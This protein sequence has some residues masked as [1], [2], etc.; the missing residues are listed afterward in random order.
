MRIITKHISL[1][2]R[3][4]AN[5]LLTAVVIITATGCVT[6]NGECPVLPE[7]DKIGVSLTIAGN[8]P[9]GLSRA[10]EPGQDS[11][12]TNGEVG[13]LAESYININDLFIF[14]FALGEE[15]TIATNDSKLKDILWSPNKKE[16]TTPQSTI[17]SDG[18]NVTL[19]T[20][21]DSKK[22]NTTDKFCIV[23][24]ANASKWVDQT[25]LYTDLKP[26]ETTL[27]DL[28]K[29]LNYTNVLPKQSE[30][31]QVLNWIPNNET[32][33]G[34]PLFGIKRVN[35][36]GYNTEIYNSGNPYDLGTV[37]LLRA[38]AKIEISVDENANQDPIEGDP[39]DNIEIESAHI[40]AGNWNTGLQLIPSPLTR[41]EGYATTGGTGQVETGPVFNNH[42]Y[43]PAQS[44]NTLYFTKVT[45]A[46][47][48]ESFIAYVP[49][50]DLSNGK[51]KDIIQ[52]KL[53]G[54]DQ[55]FNLSVSPYS[56]GLPSTGTNPYWNCIL[57]N[58]I[59]RYS[60]KGVE[61]DGSLT[62]LTL[63]WTVCPMDQV[64]ITIPPFD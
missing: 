24:V 28:Q 39:V 26:G 56:D 62:L 57:R 8:L 27:G 33:S 46:D 61:I 59:Y 58:H 31:N 19:R 36:D 42:E 29:G 40:K 22:Y 3:H 5:T 37:W 54:I 30:S 51:G 60:I 7:E 50:Y 9:S 43:D 34:I 25:S 14:T 13:T 12:D 32:S 48:K 38:L 16:I 21:L 6:E 49:E 45:S 1:A 55:T 2:F 23:S 47:G 11:E 20:F 18:E 10:N 44:S 41:M 52:I 15:E 35:L 63:K 4:L 64:G 17:Y 53:S